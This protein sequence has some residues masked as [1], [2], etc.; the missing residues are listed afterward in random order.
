LNV[1]SLCYHAYCILMLWLNTVCIIFVD[2]VNLE[3]QWS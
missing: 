3:W 2:I 1:R